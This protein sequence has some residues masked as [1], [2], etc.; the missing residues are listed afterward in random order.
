[1][2]LGSLN[3]TAGR[4]IIEFDTAGNFVSVTNIGFVQNLCAIFVA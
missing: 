3:L 1:V 2:A 4:S